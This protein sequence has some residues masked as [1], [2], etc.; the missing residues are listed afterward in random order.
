MIIV[1]SAVIAEPMRD[2]GCPHVRGWLDRQLPRSLY[3]TTIGLAELLLG[4]EVLR[5]NPRANFL[6]RR[7]RSHGFA[8]ATRRAA[9]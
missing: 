5:G 3:L 4:F 9:P 6:I 7:S 2:D 8:V 1:E